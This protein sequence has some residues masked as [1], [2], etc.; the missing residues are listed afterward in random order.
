M[1]NSG[2]GKKSCSASGF[3]GTEKPGREFPGEGI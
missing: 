1:I 3:K 2:A